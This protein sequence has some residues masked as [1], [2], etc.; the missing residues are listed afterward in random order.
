[1]QSNESK[2]EK[3]KE[4]KKKKKKNILQALQMNKLIF[5]TDEM[6]QIAAYDMLP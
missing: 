2:K 5:L 4:G 6:K 1:M 3:K